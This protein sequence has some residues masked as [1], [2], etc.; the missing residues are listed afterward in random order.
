VH[1]KFGEQVLGFDHDIEQMRDRRSLIAADITHAGLQ[2]RF[3]DGEDSF[4]AEGL[5]GAEPQRLDFFAKGAF[6]SLFGLS[7]DPRIAAFG[8]PQ[9][10]RV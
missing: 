5:A 9:Q 1:A 7:F 10:T 8:E 4:A 3:G 2:Q 6:H